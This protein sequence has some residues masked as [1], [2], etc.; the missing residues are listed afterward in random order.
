MP[1]RT[2]IWNLDKHTLGKHLVLRYYMDAWLP[3][4]RMSN[5]RVLF[6]DAFAGPG[7]YSKGEEGSPVI[8]F[9]SLIDHSAK[10]FMT[11]EI[12]YFF[13]EK[14]SARYEYLKKVLNDL[15]P[16]LPENCNYRVFNST[17]DET[18]TRVLDSIDEQKRKLAPSFVMID[19]FGVSGTPMRI[20][21][22]ILS[23]P[24][25]E[26]YVSFMYREINRFSD[27][28]N[29]EPHLDELFGCPDWRRGVEIADTEERKRFFYDLYRSQLK[30]AGAKYVLQFEL[31][32]NRELVY[33]IF[34]GTQS[35]DGCNKMK[36][37]IWKVAPFGDFKFRGSQAEQM[38][39][40]DGL[41]D[42]GGLEADLQEAFG[43]SGWVTIEEIV[44]FVKSDGTGFHTGHLKNRTLVPMEERGSIEVNLETRKKKG[45]YPDGVMLR[46]VS[47]PAKYGQGSLF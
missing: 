6:I 31:Y 14:E 29:F 38:T 12:S 2:T 34:F 20:I 25:S 7:E 22:R 3:I 10:N 15:E 1:P 46:F 17:F 37:A 47:S 24:K 41:V 11:G 18:L 39:L 26:V 42:Y 5:G 30:A 36:Q 23:N 43:D 21:G 19:P 45:T 44:N 16:E 33:A 8:A 27:H 28:P 40:G 4:M 35:L 32:E 13:I 9:R